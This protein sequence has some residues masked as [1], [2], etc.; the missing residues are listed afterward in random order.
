MERKRISTGIVL[1]A[2]VLQYLELLAGRLQRN[3]SYLVNAIV[4][5]YARL[6][7]DH[8]GSVVPALNPLPAKV[9]EL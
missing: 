9:I 7:E 8:T 5:D 6:Q 3:R 1:E 2:D 4:R